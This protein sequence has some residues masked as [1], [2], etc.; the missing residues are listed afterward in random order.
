MSGT[1]L[2]Q[3]EIR[4]S[5]FPG[6]K[7]SNVRRELRQS[8]SCTE[9]PRAR[10][11]M[12]RLDIGKLPDS[13]FNSPACSYAHNALNS[14]VEKLET[15]I[16]GFHQKCKQEFFTARK[17]FLLA[18]DAYPIRHPQFLFKLLQPIFL[19]IN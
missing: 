17:L 16:C 8:T 6:E 14:G 19:P 10:D 3:G 11:L 9:L 18:T 15:D 1:L 2:N 5:S 13:H 7:S 4:Y 12:M